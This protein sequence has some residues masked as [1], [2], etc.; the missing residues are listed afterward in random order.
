MPI[1]PASV[2]KTSARRGV[3]LTPKAINAAWPAQTGSQAPGNNQPA[4]CSEPAASVKPSAAAPKRLG[5]PARRGVCRLIRVGR[6]LA[7]G[8]S[9]ALDIFTRLASLAHG[10]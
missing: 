7:T 2:P 4:A 6:A 8:D 9:I 10:P 3:V 1:A 5:R